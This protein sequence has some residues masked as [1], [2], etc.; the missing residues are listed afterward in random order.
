MN[1]QSHY[2]QDKTK[3]RQ[4]INVKSYIFNVR[5]DNDKTKQTP[6]RMLSVVRR[7]L[8]KETSTLGEI[9]SL[10]YIK[11]NKNVIGLIKALS[12]LSAKPDPS[13]KAH[14][15]LM[16]QGSLKSLFG[17]AY[18]C[19]RII[20]WDNKF[21]SKIA[22]KSKVLTEETIRSL[23]TLVYYR[24]LD[25]TTL[26]E[27]ID[28]K[29]RLIPGIPIDDVPREVIERMEYRHAYHWDRYQ[30]F[31]EHIAGVYSVPLQGAYNLPAYA[32]PKVLSFLLL[33][34]EPFDERTII[35]Y[36][37]LSLLF[38]GNYKTLRRCICP[39][40]VLVCAWNS[41]GKVHSCSSVAGSLGVLVICYKPRS[42]S[43]RL[44]I[45]YQSVHAKVNT[46][47][48]LSVICHPAEEK[49]WMLLEADTTRTPFVSLNF[50]H[51]LSRRPSSSSSSSS[52]SSLNH[53][54]SCVFKPC[55]QLPY[56]MASSSAIK[57]FHEEHGI[58]TV[59]WWDFVADLLLIM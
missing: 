46:S 8:K 19:E 13:R 58:D 3:T 1:E 57:S 38:S 36:S 54:F 26:R 53:A 11:S 49:R 34:A 21:I 41:L 35:S 51:Q 14:M 4:S 44:L 42:D 9:V 22:R 52:S 45:R 48:S 5:G 59:G 30:G 33:S 40:Y 39:V 31:F 2:K 10:Y 24:D 56:P 50:G 12:P 20:L 6:T 7:S 17:F 29:D 16:A 18:Y 15:P 55:F 47:L 25:R 32:Q 27:L 28:F 43:S 23:S 37:S